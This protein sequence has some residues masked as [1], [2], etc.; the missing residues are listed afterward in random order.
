LTLLST[1]QQNRY[2]FDGER[3]RVPVSGRGKKLWVGLWSLIFGEGE[4]PDTIFYGRKDLK[5]V[6]TKFRMFRKFR[7]FS[8]W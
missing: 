4:L 5:I 8:S 7:M 1:R 3:D 6:K 2:N